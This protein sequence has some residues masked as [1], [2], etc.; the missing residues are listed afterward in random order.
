MSI[1]GASAGKE[2]KIERKINSI[3]Q[4]IE[5]ILGPKMAEKVFQ[6]LA[7]ANNG[8]DIAITLQ[9]IN[10]QTSEKSLRKFVALYTELEYLKAVEDNHQHRPEKVKN[11]LLK[12]KT[13]LT[14]YNGNYSPKF[15]PPFMDKVNQELQRLS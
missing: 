8:G 2:L 12:L 9:N 10:G 13:V 3:T 5:E 6:K 1:Q 7:E 4:E 11:D 15:E 14:E